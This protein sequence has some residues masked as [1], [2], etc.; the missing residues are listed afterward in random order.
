M[1]VKAID[2]T[3]INIKLSNRLMR[4]LTHKSNFQNQIAQ[5]LVHEY[6]FDIIYTEVF[7]PSERFYLDF[8]IPSRKIVVE[9]HGIQHKQHVQF[10]HRTKRD[11]NRQRDR[12]DRVRQWCKLNKFKLIEIYDD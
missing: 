7:V 2:G 1:Q 12:D 5:D 8:F 4:N 3:P 11:F 10:F 9:C 6:P